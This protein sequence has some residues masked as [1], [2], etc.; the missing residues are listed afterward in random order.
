MRGLSRASE[1]EMAG[2]MSAS[3]RGTC[4]FACKPIQVL[5]K[6]TDPDRMIY[7]YEWF[8]TTHGQIKAAA[9]Q[10][11]IKKK[12]IITFKKDLGPRKDWGI[13][14]K[15]EHNR[16]ITE[17]NGIEAHRADLV[18]EYNA[19]SGMVTREFLMGKSLPEKI[20]D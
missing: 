7:T 9:D 18:R 11:I 19:R 16:L 15:Q 1:L 3:S 8:H 13:D 12:H 6:V 14:D 2:S 20:K 4:H 10:I 5:D 17:L